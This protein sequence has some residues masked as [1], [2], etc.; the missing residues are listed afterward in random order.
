MN[1]RPVEPARIATLFWLYIF[2]WALPGAWGCMLAIVV[3]HDGLSGPAMLTAAALSASVG[4][5]VDSVRLKWR[6]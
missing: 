2:A 6:S 4:L 1:S 3:Q 5:A